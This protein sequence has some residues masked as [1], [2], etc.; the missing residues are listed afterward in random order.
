MKIIKYITLLGII[1]ISFSFTN[2][3]KKPPYEDSY[4]DE[5][6]ADSVLN[7]L[8][9]RQKLGQLFMVA[10]F[11]HPDKMDVTGLEKLVKEY[12]VGGVIFFKGYPTQQV[13][14]TN[15]LQSLANVPLF[16]GIDAEWGLAMRLDST[17]NYG[18]QM[19]LGAVEDDSLTYK[20]ATEIAL[21]CKRLGIHINFAPVIDINNNPQNPVINLRSFGENKY[22][23]RDKGLM[24]MKGLQDHGIMAVAK[25]FPGHGNTNVDSHYDLPIINESIEEL[26]KLELFP[27]SYLFKEDVG[28]VMT[29]HINLPNIDNTK[30]IGASLSSIVSTDLLKWDMGFEGLVF[31]DALNMQ[32]VA[33]FYAPGELEYLALLAGNDIL[34]Y[35]E[36]VPAALK[37]LEDRIKEGCINLDFLDYKV[38]KVLL[39]KKKYGLDSCSYISTLNVVE[40]INKPEGYIIRNNIAEQSIT[41]LGNQN[42]Y[43]PIETKPRESIAVVA[44]GSLALTQFQQIAQRYHKTT[45]FYIS[46]FTN[47]KELDI[48]KDSLNKFD[49]V[50]VTLHAISNKSGDSYGY[51]V[52]TIE[53]V[54]EIAKN[55]PTKSVLINFGSPYILSKFPD[56]QSLV[57]AYDSK[58]IIQEKTAEIVFGANSAKGKL[59]VQVSKNYPYKSGVKTQNI[60][61]PRSVVPEELNVKSKTLKEIENLVNKAI[62]NEVLPGCQIVAIYKNSIIYNKSFGSLTYTDNTPIR[63]N[64]LYDLASITKVASTTLACM[65]LYEDGKLKLNQSLSYYIPETK[66]TNKADIKIKDLLTHTAGLQP[67]IP[68]YKQTLNNMGLCDSNYCYRSQPGFNFR[69]AEGLYLSD[70]FKDSIYKQIDESSLTEKGKFVYS[71][72]GFIYLQRIIEKITEKTIDSFVEKEFYAKMNLNNMGYKPLEQFE[73]ERIVPTE[74]DDYFRRQQIRGDVH[75]PN[76]ALL[77]GVAGH[78]GLFSNAIDLAFLMNMLLNNGEYGTIKFLTPK[79]INFFTNKQYDDI[80]R[81][82]GFDKP[83]Q[84]LKYRMC[85]KYSSESSY[86]HSGFTGTLVWVDP[87]NELVYVFL[88]NRTYPNAKENKLA[89]SNLRTLIHDKLYESIR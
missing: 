4:L 66:G 43:I 86:G 23:V 31:S 13:R 73:K 27:F 38:K 45:N 58:E 89:K 17:I 44:V 82:L 2:P 9:T 35:P 7:Q 22:L 57:S 10:A 85:S 54:N 36:N 55:N 46:K 53:F 74:L 79:T 60:N 61:K 16:V 70:Y 28:G 75:D 29:A 24:Y 62:E 47:T 40:D 88:S 51:P 5:K 18:Y 15:Y 81:G 34:L 8:S 71:D 11:S 37:Y 33:K 6:W 42:Q 76:A 39:A 83:H 63:E 56:Y 87:E 19:N 26:K 49:H 77:G 64:H 48:L 21:E 78:A 50:I 12:Q 14:L 52:R 32:G 68:F 41:V 72:L 3:D 30:N 59:P 25:H 80:R 69:V 67:F 1:S 20:M 65:K 84:I